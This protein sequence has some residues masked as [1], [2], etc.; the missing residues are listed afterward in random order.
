MLRSSGSATRE[1]DSRQSWF[2]CAA[3]ARLFTGRASLPRSSGT[4]S[5]PSLSLAL[6]VSSH[7]SRTFSITSL[8]MHVSR[9]PRDLPGKIICMNREKLVQ[10]TQKRYKAIQS[11]AGHVY[12]LYIHSVPK[13]DRVTQNI[14]G[15]SEGS[16]AMVIGGN[17]RVSLGGRS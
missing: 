1:R 5:G 12:T 2:V 7:F 10:Q 6:V 15:G 13:S 8:F 4:S 17:W 9:A 14:N 11:F 3:L 16:V